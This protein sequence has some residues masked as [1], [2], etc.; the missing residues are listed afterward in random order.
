MA[1]PPAP[2]VLV[3]PAP[4]VPLV[5]AEPPLPEA[6]PLPPWPPAPPVHEA[7]SSVLPRQYSH[8]SQ[9]FRQLG[10]CV[11]GGHFTGSSMS[12]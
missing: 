6:P 10:C 4:A 12:A 11:Q 8:V 1:L 7:G 3:P 2:A 9:V 5:P